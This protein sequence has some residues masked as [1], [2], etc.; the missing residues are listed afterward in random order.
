MP[1]EDGYETGSFHLDVTYRVYG[2]QASRSAD[3]N[4]YFDQRT[5]DTSWDPDVDSNI[6]SKSYAVLKYELGADTLTDV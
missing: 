6:F 3:I 4:N 2:S 5:I 1:E